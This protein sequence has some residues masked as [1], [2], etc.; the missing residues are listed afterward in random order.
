MSLTGDI[1][2]FVLYRKNNSR[3]LK[4]TFR[5][6]DKFS[7]NPKLLILE[8][9]PLSSHKLKRIFMSFQQLKRVFPPKYRAWAVARGKRAFVYFSFTLLLGNC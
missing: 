3:R 2:R 6:V 7:K 8:A 4:E 9:F 1:Q 5:T